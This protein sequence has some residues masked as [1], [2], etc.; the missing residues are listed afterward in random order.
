[1]QRFNFVNAQPAYDADDPELTWSEA[2]PPGYETGFARVGGPVGASLMAG[3]LYEI[4]AGN[5]ICPYHDEHLDGSA[6]GGDRLPGL[7]QD[8]GV[9]PRPAGQRP[10]LARPRARLLRR[11]GVAPPADDVE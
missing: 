6:A 1:M 2:D 3:A 10:R 8:R 4:P 7:G 5:S 11:R 9:H